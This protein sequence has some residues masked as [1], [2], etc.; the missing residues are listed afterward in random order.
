[1]A[2]EPHQVTRLAP[3][4]PPLLLGVALL[5]GIGLSVSG[6]LEMVRR[7]PSD[8]V[9][10]QPWWESGE[11]PPSP[12]HPA[13]EAGETAEPQPEPAAIEPVSAAPRRVPPE[14]LRPAGRTSE[15]RAFVKQVNEY[16]FWCVERELWDEALIHVEHALTQ[17]SLAA[18]LH[19]NLGVLYEQ[20]GRQ[21]EALV[22]YERATQLGSKDVYRANLVHLEERIRESNAIPDS[23]TPQGDTPPPDQVDID[24]E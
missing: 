19:N 18:S 8:T 15:D 17:D 16:A 7:P 3:L 6:C 4:R 21:E 2:G 1:M 20:S 23:T 5:T 24:E 9:S 22:A 14:S 10:T 12:D 13:P 11:S